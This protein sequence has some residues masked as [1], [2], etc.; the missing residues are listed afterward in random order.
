MRFLFLLVC[1]MVGLAASDSSLPRVLLI[2]DSISSGYG[3]IR[4]DRL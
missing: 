4:L 2:G 3:G 1:F